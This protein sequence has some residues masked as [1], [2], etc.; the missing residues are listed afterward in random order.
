MK[1]KYLNCYTNHFQ[2]EPGK[3]YLVKRKKHL[4]QTDNS[5]FKNNDADDDLNFTLTNDPFEASSTIEKPFVTEHH[6]LWSMSYGVPVLYFHGWKSGDN[7][8]FTNI[9]N[10]NIKEYF[11]STI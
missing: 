10:S 4:L 11:Y 2:N 8:I 9:T 5:V 1:K 7:M 6:V 3:A